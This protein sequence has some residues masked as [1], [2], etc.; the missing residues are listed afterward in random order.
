MMKGWESVIWILYT[1]IQ[2]FS[3]FLRK[4]GLTGPQIVKLLAIQAICT[5][6]YTYTYIYIYI[7]I[8]MYTYIGV[9]VRI[10]KDSSERYLYLDCGVVGF[11]FGVWGS[12]LGLWVHGFELVVP[13]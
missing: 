2:K 8:Y 4:G 12:G 10:Y 3:A 6:I 9:H 1:S 7:Y 5:Y 11:G 13:D